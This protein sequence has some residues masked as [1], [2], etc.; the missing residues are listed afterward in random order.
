MTLITYVT[1]V[2]FADGILEEALRAE[3]EING[4][5]RPLFIIDDNSDNDDEE[6]NLRMSTGF[7]EKIAVEKIRFQETFTK[8]CIIQQIA[9]KYREVDAD[10]LVVGGGN[11]VIDCAKLAR[12]VIAHNENLTRF[13]LA[14]GGSRLISSKTLPELYAVPNILGFGAAVSAHAR[15]IRDDGTYARLLCRKLIPTVTICDPT[16]TAGTNSTKTASA[17]VD[18][19]VRCLEAYLSPNF[20][21]PADGIALDGLRRA[22]NALPKVLKN[23]KLSYRREMM[24]AGLNSAL[25]LQ[26]GIGTTQVI[27]DSLEVVAGTAFDQGGI[28]RL[29]LPPIMRSTTKASGVKEESLKQVLG[30]NGS[31]DLIDTLEHYLTDLPLPNRLGDFGISENH[32]SK[33]A[34]YAAAE[35]IV[36]PGLQAIET[37]Q[38]EKMM[39][40]IH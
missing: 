30:V 33:A 1:R 34:Q 12:V 24:A 40:E 22:V 21:P 11:A 32:L 3:L 19:I 25:A 38:L 20:N 28:R 18:A 17:G 23:D 6:I 37:E 39:V 26:K 10:V 9:E 13:S 16:L 27:G 5:S 8:E 14:E 31:S 15:Y 2:H 4:K 7:G 36:A 29:I 35:M